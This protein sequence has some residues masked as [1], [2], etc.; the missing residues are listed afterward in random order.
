MY[1]VKQVCHPGGHGGS[2]VGAIFWLPGWW[3]SSFPTI[4]ST[5]RL[6]V[7]QNNLPVVHRS[8]KKLLRAFPD[9]SERAL[10]FLQAILKVRFF[11][12]ECVKPIMSSVFERGRIFKACV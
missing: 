11:I 12:T 5:F 2:G 1:A 9:S 6:K 10:F 4:P 8:N 3:V 7:V